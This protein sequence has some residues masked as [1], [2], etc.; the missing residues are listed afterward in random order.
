MLEE[1][2]PNR[3]RGAAMYYSRVNLRKEEWLDLDWWVAALELNVC[4]SAYSR[5]QG[6]MGISYGDGSGSGTGGTIQ[7]LGQEGDYPTMEAWMGTWPPGSI[8]S[9]RIGRS[10]KH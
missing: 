3:A 10:F 4:V 8:P 5:E 9:L 7:V 2:V 1:D 6:I